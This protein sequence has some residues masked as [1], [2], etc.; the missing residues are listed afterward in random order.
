MNLTSKD[1]IALPLGIFLGAA[2]G[3]LSILA[4]YGGLAIALLYGLLVIPLVV[5]FAADHRR[6]L[7]WQSCILTFALCIV[8]ENSRQRAFNGAEALTVLF[9][10][11]AGGT[12][13]SSPAMGWLFWKSSKNR[14]EYRVEWLFIGIAFVGLV[15]FLWNDP[16]LLVGLMLLWL[17]LCSLK[18]ARDWHRAAEP[19]AP[20]KAT[21]VASCLLVVTIS[22]ALALRY[23]DSV[24]L[25]FGFCLTHPPVVF[26][27]V[28]GMGKVRLQ[29]ARGIQSDR[30][31]SNQS[32]CG[33]RRAVGRRR[34]REGGRLPR[35]LI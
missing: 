28:N 21:V 7:V 35:F 15:G 5:I 19:K 4:G 16:F 29:Y 11:W 25:L 13:I 10:F 8:V 1:K 33:N 23:G 3:Y 9:M 18:F 14:R 12:V 24:G 31:G 6:I 2:F 30:E 32:S 20:R 17:A 26:R 22:T 34:K 27:A